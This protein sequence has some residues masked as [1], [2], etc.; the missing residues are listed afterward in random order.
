MS[1]QVSVRLAV[2]GGNQ[3]RQ[4]LRQSGADGARA[5]NGLNTAARGVSPAFQSIAIQAQRMFGTFAGGNSALVGFVSTLSRAAIGGGA[6]GLVVGTVL[7]G[8]SAL[9]PQLGQAGKNARDAAGDM[10]QLQGSVGAV[11]GAV[12]ALERVQRDYIAAIDAQGGASNAAAQAVIA[13][14][15]AEFEARK[16]VLRIELEL[17]RVRGASAAAEL[18]SRQ[19]KFRDDATSIQMRDKGFESYINDPAAEAAYKLAGVRRPQNTTD[20]AFDAFYEG[21]RQTRLEMRRMRAEATLTDLAIKQ[22]E[23][24][25]KTT[26]ADITSGGAG[27]K[28]DP[29]KGGGGKG[30]GGGGG[31]SAA[32][33]MAQEAQKIFDSTRTAAE[34]PS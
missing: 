11:S 32:E 29:A 13:N 9:V 31:A 14:S 16:E 28:T 23:E 12:S 2:V 10:N 26:F 27:G 18:Q 20:E 15:S 4:E 34:W 19:A 24:S 1:D 6:F 5:L 22:T 30:G 21:E 33:K 17:L 25:L 3:F 7:A 8:V